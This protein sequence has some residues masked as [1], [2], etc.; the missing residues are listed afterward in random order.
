MFGYSDPEAVGRFLRLLRRTL[1]AS[2]RQ[3]IAVATMRSDFL[4]E[5][6]THPFLHDSAYDHDFAYQTVP[7]DPMPERCFA[8][9]IQGPAKLAGLRL[10]EGLAD[11]MCRDTGTRDALPLLAF[12]L[13]RLYDR[14]ST[15]GVLELREYDELGRI[16]GSLRSEA[17]RVLENAAPSAEDMNALRAAFVPTMVRVNADGGYARRR[18]Y[19]DELPKLATPLIEQLVEARLLVSDLDQDRRQTIEVT[20]EA[21]LRTWPQLADWLAEDQDKLRL[22]ESLQRASGDWNTSE[23]TSDLLI[24]RDGRLQDVQRLVSNPRFALQ[25]ESPEKA[26]LDACIEAQRAREVAERE[27]QERRLRDAESLAEARQKTSRRTL[28]GLVATLVLAV[29]TGIAGLQNARRQSNERLAN[30]REREAASRQL[31]AM[32]LSRLDRGELDSALL[33]SLEANRVQLTQEARTSLLAGLISYPHVKRHLNAHEDEIKSLV[34][35]PDSAYFVSGSKDGTIVRWD[36]HSGRKLDATQVNKGRLLTSLAVNANVALAGYQ[37]GTVHYLRI[38]RTRYRRTRSESAKWLG[39]SHLLEM[40]IL[41]PLCVDTQASPH[42]VSMRRRHN[43]SNS[44]ATGIQSARRR[45]ARTDGSYRRLVSVAYSRL[46]SDDRSQGWWSWRLRSVA[47]S[48]WHST[49]SAV[50]S[51]SHGG[52]LWRS[53]T[54]RK[55]S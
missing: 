38:W 11:T 16:E 28:I 55:I 48:G 46:I 47:T 44:P 1:E 41:W 23:R 35:S 42:G 7:V 32:A 43:V 17:H 37:D 27:E 9:I 18:A 29:A 5:F 10:E 31:A 30:E 50:Y 3:L 8:E 52:A 54:E 39:P 19:A 24:H 22:L 2:D 6:Q 12:T 26:Y 13:R 34:F 20:H 36:T 49:G 21:L 4:S 15:D 40:A 45:S 25:E 53:G 33:L 14:Y 51:Q